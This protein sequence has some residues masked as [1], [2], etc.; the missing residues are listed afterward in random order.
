[1]STIASYVVDALL[2]R[3]RRDIAATKPLHGL[4]F[5]ERFEDRNEKADDLP[6][7]YIVNYTDIEK[8]GGGAGGVNCHIRQNHTLTLQL[9]VDRR[10]GWFTGDEV[11]S[12]RK[13]GAVTLKNLILDRLETNDAGQ[14]DAGL[15]G[16]TDAPPS[17]Q[18]K[19][20][21]IFDLGIVFDIE[22]EFPSLRIQR[23]TRACLVATDP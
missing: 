1:M 20:S 18:I 5:L 22:I 6:R 7:I 13:M 12:I 17:I 16:T 4:K 8:I 3:L 10:N 15:D 21:G 11:T 14:T 19:E 23:A 2:N 9:V